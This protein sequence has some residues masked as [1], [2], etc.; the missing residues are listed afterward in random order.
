MLLSF[1]RLPGSAITSR[2]LP[3]DVNNA[4]KSTEPFCVSQIHRQSLPQRLKGRTVAMCEWVKALH[5]IAVISWMVGMLYLPRLFVDHCEAEAGS[6]QS[7]TFKVM[8]RRLLKA[9]INPAMIATWLAERR[10]LSKNRPC[11]RVYTPTRSE[12]ASLAVY[13]V[14]S[15]HVS[16]TDIT[17]ERRW[18]FT[19][20]TI[21]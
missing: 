6:R 19:F 14:H 15:Q 7:E 8:E 13:R 9:I 12:W 18:L 16:A 20:G 4:P 11:P 5:V 17:S 21:T 3:S 2:K 10:I 1:V